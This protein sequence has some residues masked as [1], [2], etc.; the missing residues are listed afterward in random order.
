ME[1]VVDAQGA[2]IASSLGKF[3]G[4]LPEGSH[5]VG[6]NAEVD[7]WALSVIGAGCER[8]K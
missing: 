2:E 5:F 3:E 7:V 1:F 4:G 8:I 6:G